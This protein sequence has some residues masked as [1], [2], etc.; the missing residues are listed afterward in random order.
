MTMARQRQNVPRP[1]IPVGVSNE[2]HIVSKGTRRE[3]RHAAALSTVIAVTPRNQRI[4]CEANCAS[5]CVKPH[6]GECNQKGALRHAAQ[7][8]I[9][10]GQVSLHTAKF[11]MQQIQF[12]EF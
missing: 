6:L 5:R 10:L 8:A 7:A 12:L 1:F 4:S 2:D 11:H 3:E 9:Q